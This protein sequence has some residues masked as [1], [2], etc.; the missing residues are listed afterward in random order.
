MR[1]ELPPS[2]DSDAPSGGGSAGAAAV[3][4]GGGGGSDSD[5]SGLSKF[6][7]EAWPARNAG[8][9]PDWERAGAGLD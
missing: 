6:D 5:S 8:E 7:W 2:S 1:R 4:G 9:R 3:G